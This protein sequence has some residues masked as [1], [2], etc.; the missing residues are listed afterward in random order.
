[1]IID[2]PETR[3]TFNY[4]CG[5]NALMSMLVYSGIEEREDRVAILADTHEAGT[6]INGVCRV[7]S[8]YGLPFKVVVPMSLETLRSSLTAGYPVLLPIQAY[9]E[10]KELYDNLWND[11]HWI[12]AIG[13]D[14]G[15]FIFEDPSSFCRT[16]LAEKELLARWHDV[17]GETRLYRW[18]CIL[19]VRDQYKSKLMRHMD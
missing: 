19:R 16:W 4:D 10:S 18:G 5:A 6:D 2:Y 14:N 9:R 15:R 12:V 3:Q 11:G 7:L 8:Y 17:D 13:Y 1:M